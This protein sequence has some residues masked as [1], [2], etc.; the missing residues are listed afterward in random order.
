MSGAEHSPA[1][2]RRT[3]RWVFALAL[4]GI[5]G[6]GAGIGLFAS[7]LL[8]RGQ[9]WS[10]AVLPGVWQGFYA[11]L[12]DASIVPVPGWR[13]VEVRQGRRLA[14]RTDELGLRPP[15]VAALAAGTARV[16][17]LGDERVFGQGVG[18]DETVAAR[19]A[20]LLPAPA[21]SERVSVANGGLPLA[22]LEMQVGALARVRT[23]V[24]P[25]VVVLHLALADDGTDDGAVARA[26]VAGHLLAEPLAGRARAS[27]RVRGALRLRTLGLLEHFLD[28]AC[29]PLGLGIFAAPDG[30]AAD[31]SPPQL[32]RL[33]GGLALDTTDADAEID[34]VF[35]R[36]SKALARARDLAPPR[37][38]L[39]VV[40]PAPAQLGQREY[41][42]ALARAGRDPAAHR[43]GHAAARCADLCRVLDIACLDLTPAFAGHPDPGSLFLADSTLLSPAGHEALARAEAPAIAA[44][45][46]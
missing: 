15:G 42:Q 12:D 3:P 31:T 37:R 38:L 19:L 8:L 1:T 11:Q 30:A 33:A 34:A 43:R 29:P 26:V 27:W 18:E 10:P 16:L 23:R 44:L 45:L 28:R 6:L 14:Y 39:L 35:L 24:A 40:L 36:W 2:R 41:E 46:R 13:N 20:A 17:L 4:L 25:D 32:A 22:G 21:G 5:L 9:G 7:E